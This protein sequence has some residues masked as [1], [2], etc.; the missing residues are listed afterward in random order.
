MLYLFLDVTVRRR[1]LESVQKCLR[2]W[3]QVVRDY[4]PVGGM[5]RPLENREVG[6][7]L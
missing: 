3:S 5:N 1:Q 6:K 2:Q 7:D 4:S